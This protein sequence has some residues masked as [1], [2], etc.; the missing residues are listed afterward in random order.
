[1][2][3]AHPTHSGDPSSS[4]VDAA[5]VFTHVLQHVDGW[6][7]RCHFNPLLTFQFSNAASLAIAG[8]P[9]SSLIDHPDLG[10]ATLIHP[11]DLVAIT[12]KRQWALDQQQAYLNEYRLIRADGAIVWVQDRA[13]GIYSENG[14]LI[15]LEG[16][17]LDITAQRAR[18]QA[19]FNQQQQLQDLYDQS[20]DMLLS[21]DPETTLVIN[22]NQTLLNTLGYDRSEVIGKSVLQLYTP[23]VHDYIRLELIPLFLSQGRLDGVELEVQS[24]NGQVFDVLLIAS[25]VY[26]AAGQI[27]QTRSLWRD[28]SKAK[29][30]ERAQQAI[31]HRFQDMIDALPTPVAINNPKLEITYLN[32]AFIQL[33]GYTRDELPNLQ[34][35][36]HLAYPDPFYRQWVIEEWGKRLKQAQQS[37]QPF[38]P[39]EV[40]IYNRAGEKL[41]I[42]ARAQPLDNDWADDHLVLLL[43]LSSHDK[44]QEELSQREHRFR[45]LF[46]TANIS[47]WNED[48]S[49]LV[50]HL[51]QLRSN[52][53]NDI[54]Q[55][56]AEHPNALLEMIP[57]F[58]VTD[59][60]PATLRLF[61]AGKQE[62]LSGF[63]QLFGPGA[64]EVV[65]Q[66]I[67]AFWRGD[68]FFRTD[69][70]LCRVDKKPIR[71]I[72]SFP[73][74]A[75]IESARNVPVS[76]QDISENYSLQNKLALQAE[77]LENIQQGIHLVSASNGEIIYSNPNLELMFGYEA[78]EL[79]GQHVSILNAANGHSPEEIASQMI[80]ALQ[81]QPH[82]EGELLNQRKDGS[83]FWTRA[84]VSSFQHPDFGLLWVTVQHDIS[85]RK[86]AQLA[87]NF[88]NAQLQAVARIQGQFIETQDEHTAF[89][90]VLSQLKQLTN[91][92]HGFVSEVCSDANKQPYIC[93]HAISNLAWD[94]PSRE[95]Y[96]A[97]QTGGI[98]FHSLENLFGAALKTKDI[99]ISNNPSQD[100]RAKGVPAG[101]PA[102]SA[103]MAI[104]VFSGEQIIGLVGLADREGGYTRALIEQLQPI[105]LTYS[106]L[107]NALRSKRE[108]RKAHEELQQRD[109]L[110]KD[111][112]EGAG[113]GVWEWNIASNK[114]TY[115]EAW[116]NLVGFS[117]AELEDSHA[118][119]E[120]R[121]HPDDIKQTMLMR[122]KYLRGELP[123]YESEYRFLC[124]D[125]SYKWLLGRG[126]VVLHD[127]QGGPLRMIGTTTDI[128]RRKEA[129]EA[130]MANRAQ[131]AGMIDS[132][133]DAIVT[134][135]AEFCIILFNRAAEQMFGYAA[136]EILGAPIETLIPLTLAAG[137]RQLMHQFAKHGNSTRKMRGHSVRQVTGLRADGSEFPVEVSISY[138]EN[139]GNPIFTA[140]VRDITERKQHDDEVQQLTTSLEARVAARTIELEKARQQAESA[141]QAK[142]AF[143]ANMSHEIRTPLNS[144]LGMSHLALQTELNEKQ[145]DYLLKISN[146]GTHLLALI[147]D[148][149]DFSKIEAG[150]LDLEHADFALQCLLHGIHDVMEPRA[151]EKFLQLDL[152]IA[153]SVP[154]FVRG[155]ELR[156]K[157]VLLNLL[158]NA[159]KFT[160]HGRVSLC[161]TAT[162]LAHQQC[163]IQFSVRDT[164]IGISAEAQSRLFQSFVQADDSTTRKYGGTGLGLAISRQLVELMSGKIELK[165]QLKQGSEFSFS[166]TLPK[167]TSVSSETL[168]T[169]IES[170]NHLEALAGKHVLLHVFNQQVGADLLAEV[171][172]EVTLANHGREALDLI[173]Q[174]SFDAVLMDV[175]MP[176]MD[177]LTASQILR[178]NPSLAQL[179]I[180]AMT[181]N[182]SN[183]DRQRCLAAGM[184]AFIGKP[185][186]PIQ[187]YRTLAHCL[188]AS[189]ASNNSATAD[190]PPHSNA[191][192]DREV[193]NTM[194]GDKPDRQRKY[195]AKFAQAMNDGLA[196]VQQLL[197]EGQLQ[198]IGEQCHRLKSIARTVGALP[199][200]DRLADLDSNKMGIP[201]ETLSKKIF[202]LHTLYHSTCQHLVQSGLLESEYLIEPTMPELALDTELHIMLIDDDEFTLDLLTQHLSDLRLTQVS[203]YL[204]AHT[205][206]AKLAAGVKADWILCDLQMPDM[207]GIAFLRQLGVLHFQ[208]QVAILSGMDNQVLKATEKLAQSYALNIHGA[209]SKP[210]KKSDLARLLGEQA[211]QTPA[212]A[213]A[214]SKLPNDSLDIAELQHGLAHGAIEL[215]YQPKVSTSNHTVI[216]AECLARWRHPTRGLLGPALFVPA[217]ETLGLVDELTFIV[218]RQ[219]VQQLKQWQ[220]MGEYFKLS[221][222]VSMDN[223]YRLELPELFTEIL[224]QYGVAAE[225]I[226]LEI[227]ETQLSHDYVLSL[228]ILTRLR[229]KGFG[230]SIDDF[231]TGFSTME[232]L[233]Q[234]P[235]TELKIDRA[236]VRGASTD[237]SAQTI[238]EHSV[239]LG[240]KFALN[241]VAEGVETQDD[242]NMVVAAGCHEVQGYLVSRPMPASEFIAWKQQWEQQRKESAK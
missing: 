130:L 166:I 43:D 171:G 150:K 210:V 93:T 219:A 134:T 176:V 52:G 164:G 37:Q 170:Q 57:L 174:Q 106:Q 237:K 215:Y 6:V 46:D 85:D 136:A 80:T 40:F 25:A 193:L 47:I 104:P 214:S 203:S 209:L 1:M 64:L 82:W 126:T 88:S 55:Y 110:W 59:V 72:L 158:S 175:Q 173:E 53:V 5:E 160:E 181:A 188:G 26:D 31:K 154:K 21:I 141:N 220:E 41:H 9:A 147:N 29:A 24:K 190:Q 228:D 180:I 238:L 133:M 179:P 200:G 138:S 192:I 23:K 30:L 116:A 241:L 89:E 17:M 112:I 206:L 139:Y 155:D 118:I 22:C 223:L 119:W 156:L 87:L 165:S 239:M 151:Q 131:L 16:M 198:K 61:G 83:T 199:L 69:L 225:S 125:G 202:E 204:N 152:D 7:Y 113:H 205:A 76:V 97:H 27:T 96:A 159:I 94:H 221:V 197:D 232:H 95:L 4:A 67:I 148:I 70:N 234:T 71:A 114:V 3:G 39:M 34:T 124:K 107:I 68:Q 135:D 28:I 120:S 178:A 18:E 172:V 143:V 66:E 90:T 186:H 62:L 115:S 227:T 161:V 100:S 145:R 86:Q 33:F 36:W 128:S 35:W 65:K 213:P 146:S 184:N 217:I 187:L 84:N 142:S 132:A 122:A 73:I 45:T 32:P 77:I 60:N 8:Y 201:A 109:Q 224:N 42:Q 91:S 168:D 216:G 54:E 153:P 101:H 167:V 92:P 229:I 49:G 78:D 137:H 162:E 189:M 230:L 140:M 79:I 99:V 111:A 183:E 74:P 13:K 231:G 208:G 233:M 56:L 240:S 44:Q 191:L 117:L 157:Q 123:R 177:G 222:N 58:Q 235:F 196:Q 169:E 63:S 38:E 127:A 212:Q 226:T 75:D 149:L 10:L 103:F 51:A 14:D 242:W 48:M 182:V 236:F 2:S 20:P 218:L 144:V 98:E 185:V 15:A 19:L 129:E 195:F 12:Q 81:T 108:Y 163:A 50:T 194:L 11:D 121:I 105:L 207:D 211:L 102:L